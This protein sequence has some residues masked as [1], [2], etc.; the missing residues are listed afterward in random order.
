M[1]IQFLLEAIFEI[2]I[3]NK[4]FLGT[5][6]VPHKI[7]ARSVQP[8]GRLLDT[9]KQA[10]KQAKYIQTKDEFYYLSQ[11]YLQPCNPRILQTFL[12]ESL[13]CSFIEFRSVIYF[14]RRFFGLFKLLEN[15][16]CFLL[17]PLLLVSL[18]PTKYELLDVQST[19]W[20]K[21]KSG[22]NANSSETSKFLPQ[23][24]IF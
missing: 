1:E 19:I 23:T 7:W 2:L 16:S 24:L 17:N 5:G 9:K 4:P 22:K 20:F 6:E 12:I 13:C 18:L 10:Y 3:I 8:F 11:Y 21:K 14:L 15:L